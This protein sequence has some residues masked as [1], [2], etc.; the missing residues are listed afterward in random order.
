MS[1]CYTELLKLIWLLFSEKQT[2]SDFL[3]DRS[4]LRGQIIKPTLDRFFN[5]E[6]FST[7]VP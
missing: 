5:F 1:K 6:K 3:S 7:I 2:S 4:E